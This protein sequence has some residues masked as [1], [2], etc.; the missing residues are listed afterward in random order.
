MSRP[1]RAVSALTLATAA[2]VLA[3]CGGDP[4]REPVPPVHST[5][6]L[7]LPTS[8]TASA[9]GEAPK[10]TNPL[11]ATFLVSDPCAALS[12][13]Q[14]GELGLA[15]GETRP[16]KELESEACRWKRT[17]ESLDSVDLTAFVGDT[18]GLNSVY[19]NKDS[20]E[21]FEPTEVAGYPAVYTGL[22][23]ARDSGTC[24]LWVGVNDQAVLH[25]M[26]NLVSAESA[27][28]SCGLAADVAEAAIT[29]LGG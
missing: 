21:Y 6:Q 26:T 8:S 11:D 27:E 2:F 16:N 13:G 18:D 14:L 19:A 23:D 4:A 12:A 1:A 28:A 25:I 24:N 5:S 29:T 7:A 10:V 20:S 3:A 9:G 15:D 22:V 17:E